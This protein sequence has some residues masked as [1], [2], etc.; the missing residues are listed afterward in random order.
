MAISSK[1]GCSGYNKLSTREVRESIWCPSNPIRRTMPPI[2]SWKIRA[3]QYLE[4]IP[5]DLWNRNVTEAW[6]NKELKLWV[7]ENILLD[8]DK[9]PWGKTNTK[10][11]QEQSEQ[12]RW[13]QNTVLGGRWSEGGRTSQEQNLC[14]RPLQ[15]DIIYQQ[16]NWLWGDFFSP[17]L[18]PIAT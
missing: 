1:Y 9:I 5:Q 4:I 10:S 18:A 14:V 7:Q 6:R 3:E 17:I 11:K 12:S 16:Q 2:R 8:R 15:A 13:S